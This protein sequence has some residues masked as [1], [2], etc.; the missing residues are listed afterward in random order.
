MSD[1]TEKQHTAPLQ[2][3]KGEEPSVCEKQRDEY[4]AGW[5]RA[6]AD[7]INYKKDE[8]KRLEE[9]GLYAHMS[10][11]R[12]LLPI[13]DSFGFALATVEEGSP[14]YKGMALIQSQFLEVLKR[15]GIEKISV[16]RGDVFDPSFHE[17]MMEVEV[18]PDA[19]AVPSGKIVAEL[20]PGYVMQGRTLRASKVTVAK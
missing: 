11:A 7:L 2:D 19:E 13:L 8:G 15:K 4:L 14:A 10:M 6:Q 9:T 18:P 12:E 3:G 17:A 5:K 16:K 20:V 1:D